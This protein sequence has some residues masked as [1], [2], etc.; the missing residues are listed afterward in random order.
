MNFPRVG[1]AAPQI[2]SRSVKQEHNHDHRRKARPVRN[3][4]HAA[5]FQRHIPSRISGDDAAPLLQPLQEETAKAYRLRQP[6]QIRSRQRLG[7]SSI[8]HGN[9]L[10]RGHHDLPRLAP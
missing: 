6:R 5:R 10:G 1:N 7:Q 2:G 8:R 4:L 9:D 3:V